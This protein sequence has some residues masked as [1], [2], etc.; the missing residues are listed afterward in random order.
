MSY[1]LGVEWLSG[2]SEVGDHFSKSLCGTS[3]FNS[4]LFLLKFGFTL[5]EHQ[6]TV[7]ISKK[8]FLKKLGFIPCKT[9]Q[10]LQGMELQEKD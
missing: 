3:I 7:N 2:C 9:E 8:D 6:K 1:I 4:V 10:P 5:R